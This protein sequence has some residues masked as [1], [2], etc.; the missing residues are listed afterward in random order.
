MRSIFTVSQEEKMRILE[1][2]SPKRTLVEQVLMPST[3]DIKK[4]ETI[5]LYDETNKLDKRFMISKVVQDL[6]GT[7]RIDFKSSQTSIGGKTQKQEVGVSYKCQDEHLETD[8]EKEVEPAKEGENVEVIK[9]KSDSFVK[10]LRKKFCM[11]N[12]KGEWVPKADFASTSAQ[13][14][15]M[16]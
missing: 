9:Y 11:K 3:P 16:V 7:E 12:S 2:H 10:R 15:D 6:N 8:I 4:G 5:N 13:A 1:M 14:S